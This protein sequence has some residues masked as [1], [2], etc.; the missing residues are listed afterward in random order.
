MTGKRTKLTVHEIDLLIAEPETADY[1][2]ATAKGRSSKAAA[3]WILNDLS[4]YLKAEGKNAA[5]SKVSSEQLGAIID[6][7]EDG[8]ISRTT[9]KHLLDRIWH[10]GGNPKAIVERHGMYQI[11]SNEDIEQIID[12]LFASNPEKVELAKA[13]PRVQSWF[14]GQAMKASN[15]LFNPA[16]VN[17]LLKQ[18]FGT[19]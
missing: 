6:M 4:K 7:T 17:M 11:D 9:A 19:E 16:V 2:E 13:N 5:Q 18:R 3:D 12:D 1:F 14:V 10:E 15:R 8:T